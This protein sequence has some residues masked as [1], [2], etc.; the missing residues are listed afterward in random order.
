MHIRSHIPVKLCSLST[1]LLSILSILTGACSDSPS[2]LKQIQTKGEIRVAII[3]IPPLYFPDES[4]IQGYDHDIMQAYARSIGAYPKIIRAETLG[5]VKRLLIQNKVDTGII[6]SLPPLPD[7]TIM[8]SIGYNPINW[9]VIGHQREK[10]PKD[11]NAVADGAI[12][13]AK[14]GRPSLVLSHL[15]ADGNIPNW[16]EIPDANTRQ[17]IKQVNSNQVKLTVVDADIY[18][19]YRHLY[20]K[21]KV[22]FS[23]QGRFPSGWLTLK[24]EDTSLV[25][26]INAFI[27]RYKNHRRAERLHHVYFDHLST[28][29]YVDTL[30]YLK[31]IKDVWPRLADLFR[32]AAQESDFD[33]LLLAAISYQ[34]SHW[35]K[36]ARSFTGVR[37]LMMLTQDT[38]KRVGI[39]NR[40]DPEQSVLGGAKYLRILKASLSGR[41]SEPDRSWMALAAYNVGL[42]HLEDARIL[43]QQA[44]DDPD[45]WIDIEKHLPK[46]SREEWYQGT[47][48]G[49]A[50]GNEPIK[51]VRRIRRYYDILRLYRQEEKLQKTDKPLQLNEL[52]FAS[53]AL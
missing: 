5:E 52:R 12:A 11:L 10:L 39:T 27:I 28:L 47:K 33:P 3:A 46:L 44:G 4:L 34:E 13:V 25:D 37:G 49:Y 41:I 36:N 23:L 48:H 8:M 53:P 22:A 9:F 19:Y 31:R 18:T 50:R 42:G 29:N 20:P 30:Y 2:Q 43:T 32:E 35:N 1:V 17:L 15:K 51:F 38:A 45:S 16:R 6:G 24:K 7:K 21:T 26:S 14:G 40:L